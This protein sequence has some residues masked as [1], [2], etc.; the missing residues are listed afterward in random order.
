M[1]DAESIEFLTSFCATP[2]APFREH[3][4]LERVDAFARKHRAIRSERDAMG[5]TLLI[6]PGKRGTKSP[7]VIFVAHL[8]H[9]GFVAESM[10]D[11]RT[12]R[13]DFRGGVMANLMHGAKARFFNPDGEVAA[14][15]LETTADE[16]G[17]CTSATLRVASHVPPETLGMFDLTPAR[18]SGKRLHSRAC[19]DL[20]GAAAIL[21][22]MSE[23]SA[24]P[25]DADVGALLTRG[26]EEGFVGAIGA[27]MTP[28]LLRK[29]DRIISIE[30]SAE[31]PVARQGEG[32]VLRVG[33]RTSIFNS[34][35][36]RFIFK[37]AQVLAASDKKFAYQ[38]ALMPGG[39]CEATAFDAWGYAAAA[40]CVPLG[41]YHNMDRSR[42]KIAA[43]HVHLDDWRNMVKLFIAVARNIQTFT[44]QHDDLRETLTARFEK[45]RHRLTMRGTVH[46]GS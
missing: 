3:R 13:A 9:P 45:H 25:A 44:G 35:F 18:V 33:D 4:V 12:L 23:L 8:D 20:A 6:R 42:E 11:D 21:T 10:L 29:D 27:C 40:L 22:M 36:S 31:Q 38:R 2:T 24:K 17:R 32:V 37:C 28:R 39:T 41:N 46:A 26:E 5:N 19:D 1:T 15:V 14:K 16:S 34:A 7:R 43:E 30:C